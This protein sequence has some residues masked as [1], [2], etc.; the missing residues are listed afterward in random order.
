MSSTWKPA[1]AN[2]CRHSFWERKRT[3][4][5][6]VL[7]RSDGSTRDTCRPMTDRILL[8]GFSSLSLPLTPGTNDWYL[9]F[10]TNTPRAS[11]RLSIN[12]PTPTP[13]DPQSEEATVGPQGVT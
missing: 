9:Y 2:S 7:A 8:E 12:A 5:P 4:M 13:T 11:P 1:S 10:L 3:P 6:K